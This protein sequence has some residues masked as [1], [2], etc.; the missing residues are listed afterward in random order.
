LSKE[1]TNYIFKPQRH[2]K[3]KFQKQTFYCY[4]YNTNNGTVVGFVALFDRLSTVF[5]TKSLIR[6]LTLFLMDFQLRR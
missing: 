1:E 3:S 2:P 5:V 4:R 6:Y